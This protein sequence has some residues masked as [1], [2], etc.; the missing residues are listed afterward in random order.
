M[1]ARSPSLARAAISRASPSAVC[2]TGNA[3][4]CVPPGSSTH[5]A[6]ISE[7]QSIPTK[8]CASGSASDAVSPHGCSDD[9]ARRL[10]GSVNDAQRKIKIGVHQL[11]HAGDVVVFQFSNADAI[12]AERLKEGHFR[13]WSHSGLEEV[14]DLAHHWR[15]HK[16]RP[17]LSVGF[18]WWPAREPGLVGFL[19]ASR[20]GPQGWDDG[21]CA[22]GRGE[23]PLLTRASRADIFYPGAAASSPFARSSRP[24]AAGCRRPGGALARITRGGGLSPRREPLGR[25]GRGWIL[26]RRRLDAGRRP[27]RHRCPTTAGLTAPSPHDNQPP[28]SGTPRFNVA[29]TLAVSRINRAG[30]LSMQTPLATRGCQERG[31]YRAG[32]G[33]AV[34]LSVSVRVRCVAWL[35]RRSRSC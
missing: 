34:S 14:A 5:T 24:G 20:G 13:P 12:A 26:R 25:A 27:R 15:G 31:S 32:H 1:P 3:A 16:E 4:I 11:G 33:I 18:L 35:I 10:H 7:A 6:W 22:D 2:A 29:L 30:A 21:R 9:P 23:C 17:L 19:W 28:S 8:N